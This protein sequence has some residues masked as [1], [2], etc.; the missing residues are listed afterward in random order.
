[1]SLS[2]RWSPMASLLHNCEILDI[3]F[4]GH[5][6][7]SPQIDSIKCKKNIT[8]HKSWKCSYFKKKIMHIFPGVA[9]YPLL[10]CP[11]PKILQ[12]SLST[13]FNRPK[14]IKAFSSYMIS[15]KMREIFWGRGV[16][17]PFPSFLNSFKVW[18]YSIMKALQDQ[19]K[20]NR[21]GNVMCLFQPDRAKWLH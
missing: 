10:E 9:T 19:F 11:P 16:T 8:T 2:T 14:S 3:Y 13:V 20:S 15:K 1:M 18:N 7:Q 5:E 6:P 4:G 21:L 17:T 12:E